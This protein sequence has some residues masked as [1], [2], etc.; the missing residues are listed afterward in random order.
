M[1]KTDSWKQGDR[2]E[3]SNS[4]SIRKLKRAVT[5]RTEFQNMKYT[6]HQYMTKVF[7]FMQ[8]KLV[9]TA[10]NST[11]ALEA[12]R[13]SVLKWGMFMSSS[14]KAASHLGLEEHE[15]RGNSEF[16]QYHT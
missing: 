6:N 14:M 10:G 3:S 11:F 13:T 15:L 8:K 12:L 7:Q 4:T 1:L 16:I 5:P 9:S 2:E